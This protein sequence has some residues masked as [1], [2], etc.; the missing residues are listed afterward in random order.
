MLHLPPNQVSLT[1]EPYVL[2]G[3]IGV[4]VILQIISVHLIDGHQAR[5]GPKDLFRGLGHRPKADGDISQNQRHQQNRCPGRAEEIR[6]GAAAPP[7]SALQEHSA[8]CRKGEQNAED[9]LDYGPDREDQVPEPHIV[10]LFH[11]PDSLPLFL[12]CVALHVRIG[13][14][15]HFPV[16]VPVE[17][18]EQNA[19]LHADPS[20]QEGSKQA[21]GQ[22]QRHH[23]PRQNQYLRHILPV[24]ETIDHDCRQIEIDEGGQRL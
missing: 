24:Q 9:A 20:V 16:Q 12:D 13:E 8:E 7:C 14:L 15:H 6:Q 18:G 19:L 21:A 22:V 23:H 11:L 10:H 4:N 1:V 17:L 3:M 5:I 2:P